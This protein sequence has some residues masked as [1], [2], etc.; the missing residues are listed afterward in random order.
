M[1]ST[2]F[3]AELFR[4][5]D[6]RI[7]QSVMP[8]G[9]GGGSNI[10]W[11][12]LGLPKID[13]YYIGGYGMEAFDTTSLGAITVLMEVPLTEVLS[14]ASLVLLESSFFIDK[15]TNPLGFIVYMNLEKRVWLYLQ[16]LT[17]LRDLVGFTSALQKDTAGTPIN[18]IYNGVS[19]VE[20]L[21]PPNGLGVKLDN[22]FNGRSL[23]SNFSITLNN[24]DNRFGF[25]DSNDF[26]N[27]QVHLLKSVDDS[28]PYESFR[29]IRSG[30]ITNVTKDTQV[31]KIDVSDPRRSFTNPV[32][33]VVTLDIF[34]DAP[35]ASIGK[36]IGI[37]Y[38][39]LLKVPLLQVIEGIADP[40]NIGDNK[41]VGLDNDY[42]TSFNAV[43]DSDGNSIGFATLG[44][45]VYSTTLDDDG[46]VV[47]PATADM[48]GKLSA[49]VKTSEILIDLVATFS[50]FSNITDEFYDLDEINEYTDN[51]Y[52][53]SLYLGKGDLSKAIEGITMNDSMFFILK[54]DGR[55]TIRSKR[56]GN[57]DNHSYESWQIMAKS[58]NAQLTSRTEEFFNRLKLNFRW[59]ENVDKP[60]FTALFNEL[61]V[62]LFL[63]FRK[64]VD[65]TIDTRL[66]DPA[67]AFSLA[68]FY[69]GQSS[70]IPKNIT[71]FIASDTS[72]VNLLDTV[73]LTINIAGYLLTPITDWQ[74][75]G[76]D[77]SQN[78]LELQSIVT[79]QSEV[80][81]DDDGL[82]LLGV[83]NEVIGDY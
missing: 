46:R 34:P 52:D 16:A 79:T 29:R 48:T 50:V 82:N 83:D 15:V 74:V 58:Q 11:F 49:G 21:A 60:K 39:E 31:V 59:E 40:P 45:E 17:E 66:V 62:A 9:L 57:V 64:N 44:N 38:G 14:L 42:F 72:E 55:F 8:N 54:A 19:Y 7:D 69:S 37:G 13:D 24:Q 32:N 81:S 10:H 28:K 73:Q 67:D 36:E 1:G 71:L 22:S 75:I 20:R 68:S 43:Y 12:Y 5:V 25:I 23:Y 27:T 61:T 33:Q 47:E 41:Y 6:K 30:L 65:R 78:R 18:T 35:D 3:L 63:K 51:A 4:S 56:V 26:L 70:D 2:T 76:V 80:I 77:R 53:I